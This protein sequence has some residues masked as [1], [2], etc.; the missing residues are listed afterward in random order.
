[1]AN[2]LNLFYPNPSG[3]P[4]IDGLISQGQL[5]FS[6]GRPEIPKSPFFVMLQVVPDPGRSLCDFC[7]WRSP[8]VFAH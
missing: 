3:N 7:S 6:A 1:M 5:P 4:S 8:S 2:N